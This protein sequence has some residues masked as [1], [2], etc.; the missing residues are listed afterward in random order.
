MARLLGYPLELKDVKVEPLYPPEMDAL[1]VE[2][3]LERLAQHDGHFLKLANQTRTQGHKLR[4]VIEVAEGRCQAHLEQLPPGDELLR[5]SVADSVLAFETTRYCDSALIVR[6][7][8][9]GPELTASGVLA[10]I[11]MLARSM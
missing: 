4:Y 10:D 9:S 11:L 1:S 8:G 5:P 3:F 2:E 6:G 7:K